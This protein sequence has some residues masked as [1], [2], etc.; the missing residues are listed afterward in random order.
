MAP[1]GKC[2]VAAAIVGTAAAP[3]A[4]QYQYP[5]QQTYPQQYPQE[6]YPQEQYP[7][8]QYP[9]G[10]QGQYPY[11]DQSY[12]T[13]QNVMGAII[14]QLIGNRY[15][16]S[17]RQAIHQCAYAAVQRAQGYNYAGGGYGHPGYR[18]S[19][20]VTAI[21]D[22]ERRSNSVRVRG[23]LGSGSRYNTQPYDPRYGNNGGGY[24]YGGA[25]FSFRCDVDYRG[26]VRNIHVDPAYRH[27]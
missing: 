23:M 24:G 20:R 2:M 5:Q 3:A 10:Q 12:G 13:N 9:Q 1:F 27:Y 26:Y 4:A 16:V 8:G 7:Q 21:N 17:D 18:N 25:Q 14:D 22:I 6:Q 11:P 19:L 15:N